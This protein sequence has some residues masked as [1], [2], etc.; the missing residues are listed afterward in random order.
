MKKL[1]TLVAILTF[2]PLGDQPFRYGNFALYTIGLTTLLS[3]TTLN[4]C[5]QPNAG[6]ENWSTVY[7]LL[8]PDNW[9]TGNFGSLASPPNPLSA[10]RATGVDKH[11]GNYA[12]QLKTAFLNNNFFPQFFADTMGLVF[13]GRLANSPPAAKFGYPYTGRPEKLEFWAK[14]Q[15]VGNDIAEV[16]VALR[17]WNGIS[18]DTIAFGYITF[19]TTSQYALFQINLIYKL[20]GLPDTAVIGIASSMN[21]GT[22]R[23]GSTLFIDDLAYTG[24]VGIDESSINGADKIKIFPNPAKEYVTIHTQIEDAENVQVTDVT[25]RAI[26][27][28]K[29]QNYLANINTCAFAG[30][31][32]LY[33]ICDKK[34]KILAKGKFNVAK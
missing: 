30:G 27:L 20:P 18:S 15:P 3:M 8:E 19:G 23:V 2:R 11:S 28:Y 33:E 4:C 10:F 6:F 25:G 29:I 32:Y 34:N 5:A 22:A 31:I 21:I 1:I 14:Y 9:Q 26:G 12:L 17:K 24:W 7:T 13:T 16:G